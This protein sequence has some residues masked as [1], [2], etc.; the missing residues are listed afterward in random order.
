MT[1][2]AVGFPELLARLGF[3]GHDY[4][5]VRWQRTSGDKFDGAWAPTTEAPTLA[6]QHPDENVWF[7]VNKA[8][9]KGYGRVATADVTRLT[10]LYADLDIKVGGLADMQ[11]AL[12]VIQDMSMLLGTKPGGIILSGHGLQPLWTVDPDDPTA[13][14]TDN[15]RGYT[16]ALM[17]R[18]GRLLRHVAN[19]RGGKVDGVFD[20]ARVLRVPGTT[21]WKNPDQPV[22]CQVGLTDGRPLTIAEIDEQLTMY[23]AVEQPGDREKIGVILSHANGWQWAN[24]TRPAVLRAMRS[25]EDALPGARHP[26]LI[27][28]ATRLANAHRLGWVTEHDHQR[29][30]DILT[31]RFNWLLTNHGTKREAVRGE[32]ADAFAFGHAKAQSKS[33]HDVVTDWKFWTDKATEDEAIAALE[34][35]LTT[36]HNNQALNAPPAATQTPPRAVDADQL[37]TA[38]PVLQHIHNFARA[39]RTSPLAVLGVALA[40][41]VTAT[42]PTVVL[43]PLIGGQASINLFIGIVGPSGSGKGAAEAVAEDAIDVGI[44]ETLTPGS[45]EGIAHG[46][47]RRTKDGPEQHTK[48]VLFSLAEIDTLAALRDRSG[49]TLLPELRKAWMGERLGFAYADPTKRL[50]VPAHQYRMTLVAGIQPGRA[51]TLLDDTDGGTPQRFLWLP[52]TDPDAPDQPPDEPAR[53]PWRRPRLHANS[54]GK[55]IVPVCDTAQRAV[56]DA[57]LA[58]LR[59]TGDAL[60]G[61]ALLARMKVAVA[62]ALLEQRIEITDDDWRIAGIVMEISD[63]TRTNVVEEIRRTATEIN[64]QKGAAEGARAVVVAETLEAATEKRVARWVVRKLTANG[65]MSGTE[66]RRATESKVRQHLSTVLERLIETGLVKAE[67]T[68]RDNEGHGGKGVRY[69]VVTT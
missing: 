6:A 47:M 48:A 49:S 33:D 8:R 31:Q 18:F 53:W 54:R 21:N 12:D 40:R 3:N 45:G 7:S 66:L 1:T 24:Q 23:G 34:T 35:S 9:D 28:E 65:P 26:W 10:C 19:T 37:W 17:R 50:P 25:W 55:V 14:I 57:R 67:D 69:Q 51:T 39:R 59:G 36:D 63:Q 64:R 68:D 44:I 38:R 16:V 29:G 60:D 62:L 43:P 56:D 52:V 2:P 4:V 27:G 46:Y 20:L 13:D 41:V 61:H 22:P 32:L 15:N 30:I 11:M 58:R 42:D 5:S